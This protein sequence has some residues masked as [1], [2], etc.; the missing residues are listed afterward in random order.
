MRT[1]NKKCSRKVLNEK[2]TQLKKEKEEL[3]GKVGQLNTMLIML[4]KKQQ[5]RETHLLEEIQ[6]L[7][8]YAAKNSEEKFFML[9]QENKR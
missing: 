6:Y 7:K 5:E 8:E 1:W 4:A 3:I 9:E 2:V